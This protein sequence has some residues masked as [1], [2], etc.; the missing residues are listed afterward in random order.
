V[1]VHI[2]DAAFS[3]GYGCDGHPNVQTEKNIAKYV[4]P[5]VEAALQQ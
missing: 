2:P 5:Y 4:Y 3:G 1:Y